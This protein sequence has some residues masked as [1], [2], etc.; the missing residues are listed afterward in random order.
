MN[1]ATV[2]SLAAHILRVRYETPEE[3]AGLL[4][5]QDNTIDRTGNIK[6]TNHKIILLIEQIV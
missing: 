3:W 4:I 2:R 1:T 6:I 5:A